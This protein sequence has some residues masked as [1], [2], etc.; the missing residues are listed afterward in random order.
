MNGTFIQ[1]GFVFKGLKETLKGYFH[2][3]RWLSETL[4]KF[5]V[6]HYDECCPTNADSKPVRYNSGIQFFNGTAWISTNNGIPIVAQ[7][8]ISEAGAANLTSY[9]TAWSIESSVVGTLAAGTYS[10][11]LKKIT[12]VSS[13]AQ[14]LLV[15][16]NLTGGT[17]IAFYNTGDSVILGWN[18]TNWIIIESNGVVVA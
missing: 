3:E 10:G 1:K 5:K 14:L 16:I 2:L 11:Q 9:H 17:T 6:G 13:G 12:V 8:N 15:P 18:G 7:Q 4:D